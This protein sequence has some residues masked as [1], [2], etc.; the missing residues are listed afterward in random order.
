MKR[1]A[2]GEF[3]VGY[4]ETAPPG[5]ARFTRR[6]VLG[7]LVALV[8]IAAWI[9][10]AQG[11]LGPGSFEFGRSR[12]FEGEVRVSPYPH[13]VLVRPGRPTPQAVEWSA[14]HLVAF[15]KHGATELTAALD[16]RRATIEGSLIFRG[17]DTMIEVAKVRT[18]PGS[19]AARPPA[20]DFGTVTVQGEIVDSKCYFGAMKPGDGKSHRA[21]AS[22]CIRGGIPPVLVVPVR[23]GGALPILLVDPE[24]R[25]VNDRVLD[26][27]AEPVEIT[28]RL[29]REGDTWLLAADPAAYR[30]PAA[31]ERT[32]R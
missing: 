16:G 31:S 19:G 10:T 17:S 30:R 23:H 5:I 25:A 27:V 13:L 9:A 2:R 22:L 26:R 21:C 3:Y 20:L 28:G 4:L 12:L 15:G 8:G 24:R 1:M 18:V 7:L 11:P 6:I 32:P 29:L 14:Y